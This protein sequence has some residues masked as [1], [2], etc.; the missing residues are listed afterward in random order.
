MQSCV[1]CITFW[2]LS[3]PSLSLWCFIISPRLILIP[4]RMPFKSCLCHFVGKWELFFGIHVHF[5]ELYV[6]GIKSVTM[7]TILKGYWPSVI[8]SE[9]FNPTLWTFF[10]R[11]YFNGAMSISMCAI[12][13]LAVIYVP[14]PIEMWYHVLE[15][16]MNFWPFSLPIVSMWSFFI[17]PNLTLI[18][19]RMHFESCWYNLSDSGNFLCFYVCNSEFNVS[20][21]YW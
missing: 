5:K 14:F 15:F 11:S 2:P 21:W 3:L 1:G 20:G 17:S 4:C 18:P 8:I 13:C 6:V 12:T 16:C 9:V 19:F 10:S 7:A